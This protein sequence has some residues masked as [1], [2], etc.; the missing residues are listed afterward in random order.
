MS[1]NDEDDFIRRETDWIGVA[2]KENKP[3]LG[4]CLGAQ[5]LARHLG[6]RVFL[7]PEQRV[8]IGYHAIEPN[9]EAKKLGD[10]PERVYQWHKEGFDLPAGRDPAGEIVEPVS[11]PGVQGRQ[12]TG[13]AVPSR[14]YVRP[15]VPMDR[16]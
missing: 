14:D 15:G 16:L 12:C 7:D 13:R 1:A 11:E 4:V 6:A 10:W 2:L 8:E 3:Y 5:M 9:S